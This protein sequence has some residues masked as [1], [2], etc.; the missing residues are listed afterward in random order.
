VLFTQ[1]SFY[2]PNNLF[3]ISEVDKVT[4]T[5]VTDTEDW[6]ALRKRTRQITDFG[7]EVM[8]KKNLNVAESFWFKGAGD[9]DVQG[10]AIKPFGWTL[11]DK[12]G[13]WPVVL[14]IHGGTR[15]SDISAY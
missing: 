8:K 7:Y 10:W 15:N 5:K 4:D 13:T 2:G 6:L 3:V 9:K 11:N 14:L 12:K 1:S